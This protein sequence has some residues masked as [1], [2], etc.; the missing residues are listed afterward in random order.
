[1]KTSVWSQE[2]VNAL[3]VMWAEG[4]SARNI[5]KAINISSRNAVIGKAHRLGLEK[6]PSP[7]KRF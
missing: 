2:R 7:I 5:A 4:V 6:R 3:K 1:M